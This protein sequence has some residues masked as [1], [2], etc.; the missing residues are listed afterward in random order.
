MEPVTIALGIGAL[1]LAT[2]PKPAAPPPRPPP[3]AAPDEFA[4]GE[5][6]ADRMTDAV[7]VIGALQGTFAAAGAIARANRGPFGGSATGSPVEDARG[8]AGANAEAVATFMGNRVAD[9][10]NVVNATATGRAVIG[11]TGYQLERFKTGATTLATSA[12]NVTEDA[13]ADA[14]AAVEDGDEAV[15]ATINRL[16][17]RR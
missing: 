5:F 6:L 7:G 9:V 1:Y 4:A 13:A 3:P 8:T 14:T 10:S 12:Q 11:A 15:A 16:F 2:R 17:G